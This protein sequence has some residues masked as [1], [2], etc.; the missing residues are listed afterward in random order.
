[1]PE[2]GVPANALVE[3]PALLRRF[4]RLPDISPV[5]SS[6]LIRRRIVEQV[7]GFEERFRGLYEDQVFFAKVSLAA[8]VF[9]TSQCSARYRQHANSNCSTTQAQH[10]SARAAFLRW[11]ADYTSKQYNPGTW[12]TFRPK[13][14]PCRYPKLD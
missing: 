5:P 10:A 14:W 9:V 1:M 7:G 3:A 11:L 8:S 2:P 12:R 6:V 4:L 13:F